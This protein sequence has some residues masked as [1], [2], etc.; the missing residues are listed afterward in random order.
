M[1]YM[2]I[3]TLRPTCAAAGALVN[4]LCC[5][6]LFPPGLLPLPRY[7]QEA[8]QRRAA[9]CLN[10]WYQ[11]WA[12]WEPQVFMM[13]LEPP[14]KT[15]SN[16][17]ENSWYLRMR[18]LSNGD[19]TKSWRHTIGKCLLDIVTLSYDHRFIFLFNI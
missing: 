14:W 8:Q 13:T 16:F 19:K 11:S 10:Q 3:L 17:W 5:P 9:F 1:K 18:G 12:L 7:S 2:D 4:M 6:F 15:W